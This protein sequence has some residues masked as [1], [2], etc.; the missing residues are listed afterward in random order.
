MRRFFTAVIEQGISYEADFS[1]EPYESGWASEARWFVRI[2]DGQA[3]GLHITANPEI[4]PD[5][6]MWLSDGTDPIRLP[7]TENAAATCAQ[8]EFGNWLR[9][10]IAFDGAPRKVKFLIY[11]A[12][13]E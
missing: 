6:L 10:R 12:L 13:K 2:L 7:A 5:G 4:S 9:L 1:T 11:L 3:D 8:K